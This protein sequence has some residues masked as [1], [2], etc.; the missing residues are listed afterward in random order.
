MI[1]FASVGACPNDKTKVTRVRRLYDIANIL[2][3]AYLAKHPLEP[4]SSL[5]YTES[6]FAWIF[7]VFHAKSCLTYEQYFFSQIVESPL[8]AQNENYLHHCLHVFL[9]KLF[10][11]KTPKNVFIQGLLLWSTAVNTGEEKS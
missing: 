8:S 7:N 4:T 9:S 1:S 5:G 10:I 2:Q 6:I 11:Y 3:V